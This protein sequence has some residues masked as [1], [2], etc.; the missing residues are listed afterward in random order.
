MGNFLSGQS[1][2][3]LT[4]GGKDAVALKAGLQFHIDE[5]IHVIY[6]WGKK[7]PVEGNWSWRSKGNALVRSDKTVDQFLDGMA[8]TDRLIFQLGDEKGIVNIG[9]AERAAIPDLKARCGK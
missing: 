3:L 2:F 8:T 1:T 4:C 5:H 9:E 6:R 7:K